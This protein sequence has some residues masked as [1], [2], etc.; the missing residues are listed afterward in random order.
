MVI[1]NGG[2][3]MRVQESVMI[4]RCILQHNTNKE[5]PVAMDKCVGKIFLCLAVFVFKHA[6]AAAIELDAVWRARSG[7]VK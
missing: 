6:Q 2:L 7:D 3:F 4:S 5:I 1:Q